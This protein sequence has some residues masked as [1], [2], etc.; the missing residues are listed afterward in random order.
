MVA[1]NHLFGLVALAVCV[2]ASTMD[3]WASTDCSGGA[4]TI[5]DPGQSGSCSQLDPTITHSFR[6]TS[7]D[8]G[9]SITVYTDSNCSNGFSAGLGD[10]LSAEGGFR[11]YSI[12]C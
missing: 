3:F 6:T 12:D 7:V 1:I 4:S 2:S 10:C 11:S 5:T 8:G 9:C